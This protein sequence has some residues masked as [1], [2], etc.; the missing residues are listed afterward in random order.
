MVGRRAAIAEKWHKFRH[1]DRID[2]SELEE[3]APFGVPLPGEYIVVERHWQSLLDRLQTPEV[4]P[5]L[6]EA[7]KSYPSR[8]Y[9]AVVYKV[10]CVLDCLVYNRH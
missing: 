10:R 1:A 6:E 3:P 9:C 8:K 4:P 2:D 5:K 7:C